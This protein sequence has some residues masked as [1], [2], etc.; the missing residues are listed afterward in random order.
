MSKQQKENLTR[1]IKLAEDFFG[2]RDDPSQ[3]SVTNK[4]IQK[5][6]GLHPAAISEKTTSK[7]PVAWILIIPSTKDLMERFIG[8]R[9]NERELYNK[10][11]SQKKFDTVYLCSALVLP[12]YRHRGLAK[13]LAVKAVRSVQK[14]HKITSLFYWAFSTE[15]EKLASSIAKELSLPLYKRID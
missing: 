1:M 2:A 12:E 13:S 3:I 5:L 15:G 6:K 7:G 8:K 11:V 14:K 10:T 4:V 9:I